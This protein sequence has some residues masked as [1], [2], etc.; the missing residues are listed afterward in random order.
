VGL[1]QTLYSGL[2]FGKDGTHLYAVFDSL[3]APVGDNKEA[4]GNA[5]AVYEFN[6]GEIKP[7]HCFR[8]RYSS[9]PWENCKIR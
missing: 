3:S 4:T 8:S 9:W 5:V 7:Q 2:A 1:P 6:N